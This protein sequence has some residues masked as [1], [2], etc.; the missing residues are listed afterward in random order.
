MVK[1]QAYCSDSSVS[2]KF[3]L[4]LDT[5]CVQV[6]SLNQLLSKVP[7]FIPSAN[8]SSARAIKSTGAKS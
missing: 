7:A 4:E 5:K 3:N 8:D 2:K 1:V 6:R